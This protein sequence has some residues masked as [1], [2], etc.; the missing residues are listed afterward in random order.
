MKENTQKQIENLLLASFN[1][2]SLRD[3]RNRWKMVVVFSKILVTGTGTCY[4]HSYVFWIPW[5]RRHLIKNIRKPQLN[6][7]LEPSGIS[8][9][10]WISYILLFSL[11][12]SSTNTAIVALV[13]HFLWWYPRNNNICN[14][15][16]TSMLM[17]SSH[18]F[19]ISRVKWR[20]L[21]ILKAND[22]KK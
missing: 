7:N 20:C 10:T 21:T 11:L 8:T 5:N 4:S 9:A 17:H 2:E 15:H 12:S 14:S 16:C 19:S 22:T 6:N 3:E 1:H 18:I 13:K